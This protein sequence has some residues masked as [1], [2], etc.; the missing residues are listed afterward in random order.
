MSVSNA[1]IDAK[2]LVQQM[3]CNVVIRQML[4]QTAGAINNMTISEK[5]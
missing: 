3:T 2:T 1:V 5:I 4:F